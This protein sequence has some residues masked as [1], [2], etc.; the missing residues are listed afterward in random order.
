MSFGFSIDDRP[1]ASQNEQLSAEYHAVTPGYFRAM[2]I[3]LRSGRA[4]DWFDDATA[5]PVVIINETMA[6]RYW[7][8][9]DPLGKSVSVVS[10]DGRISREIVGVIA[11]VRHAGLATSPRVEV[12]VP[13]SQ[14]PWAFVTLVLRGT[15]G[16]Q[17]GQ[18][19]RT[20][21]AA[22]D[23][24]LPIGAVLPIERYVAQ[25]LAPLR[26]QMVLVG[27]FAV[28]ALAL[29]ALGIY[30]V[31]SYLVSLR[32]NEI[33][34]RMALGA[35]SSQVFG[36]VVGQGVWLA[37]V[38][39]VLG[40]SVA[41]LT[42]RHLSGLLF[43]VAPADTLVFVAV[44]ALVLLMAILACYLPARRAMKVDPATALREM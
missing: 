7:P 19:V 38:G 40:V 43:E 41:L 28:T 31:V 26:F 8:N 32:T 42:T 39:M 18:L 14:D 13:L 20:E 11:D 15:E 37:G 5:A 9:A 16:S 35:L 2:G 3:G 27:L 29:A 36:T 22:L 12:Y 17:I 44:P 25:W 4:F 1:D 10:Q 34:V 30:G 24:G 23:S 21:L 6:R 33:S